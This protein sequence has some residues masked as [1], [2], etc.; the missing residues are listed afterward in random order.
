MIRNSYLNYEVFYAYSYCSFIRRVVT[1]VSSEGLNRIEAVILLSICC[2][3]SYPLQVV[4]FFIFCIA[5]FLF[6]CYCHN[7]IVVVQYT[8]LR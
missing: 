6:L 8:F 5:M 3:A 1:V 7:F 4:F 2:I